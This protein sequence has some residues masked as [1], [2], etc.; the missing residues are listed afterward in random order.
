[1][2]KCKDV[3]V[4]ATSEVMR[5]EHRFTDQQNSLTSITTFLY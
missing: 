3:E 4:T 2:L 1:M 5:V